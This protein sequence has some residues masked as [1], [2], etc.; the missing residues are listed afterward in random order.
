[1][2]LLLLLLL[3]VSTTTNAADIRITPVLEYD[4]GIV[5]Q[6]EDIARYEV[7][8]SATEREECTDEFS[9]T[10]PLIPESALPEGTHHITVRVVDVY[11]QEGTFTVPYTNAFRHPLP[12]VL[13][14]V[15][16]VQVTTT[17]EVV[18]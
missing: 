13:S 11:G 3:I 16:R 15:R 5:L 10:A 7:C 14:I 17:I 2:K 4:T 6:L 1:M 8:V 12:P 9:V 18:E